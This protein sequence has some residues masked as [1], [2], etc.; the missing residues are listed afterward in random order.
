[1][2]AILF[3]LVILLEV[4]NCALCYDLNLVI[5]LF[6]F[7]YKQCA[8]NDTW[9]WNIWKK[10]AAWLMFMQMHSMYCSMWSLCCQHVLSS[11]RHELKFLSSMKNVAE[12]LKVK[13]IA[14]TVF[15]IVYASMKFREQY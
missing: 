3:H 10:C 15:Y 5:Y 2:F 13:T 6:D 7:L 9:I 8:A 11:Q 14:L 4:N 12:Q 1:M